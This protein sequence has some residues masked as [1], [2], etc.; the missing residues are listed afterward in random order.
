MSVNLG[1]NGFGRIGRLVLRAA[2]ESARPV[3]IVAVNDPFMSLDYLVYQLKYDSAH[4]RFPFEVE[5]FD[6]GIIVNGKKILVF[7]EKDP[8][9]I[10]WGDSGVNIVCESTGAFLTDEKAGLHLKGGA[11][12]VIMS[13]P[14]KDKDTPTFVVGVN[15]LN[16][17]DS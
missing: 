7:A 9:N 4:L 10:K 11:K 15:H 14:S 12:K 2:I 5:K 17:K 8:A 3:N 13:A 6:K 16:Y 1:I